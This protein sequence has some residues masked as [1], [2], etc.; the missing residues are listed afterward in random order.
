MCGCES[1][2]IVLASRSKRCRTSGDADMCDGSTFTATVR[3]SRV[4]RAL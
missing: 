1:C 4:S 2:E 3:S